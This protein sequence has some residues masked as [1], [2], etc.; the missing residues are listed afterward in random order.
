MDKI[1]RSPK[2][3]KTKKENRR[4]TEEDIFEELSNPL[5]PTGKIDPRIKQLKI[6][7]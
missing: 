1:E 2:P 5:S 6:K 7:L 3:Q 4:I